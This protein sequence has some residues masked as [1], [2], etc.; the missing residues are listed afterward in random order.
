[1]A[2]HLPVVES[3]HSIQGEGKHVGKSAF[4]IRLAKCTVGCNWCDTKNSWSTNNHPEKS[5]ECLAQETATARDNGAAFVVITGGEPLH[6]N[7]N[8]LCDA[9]R[10]Q[11]KLN[12]KK[13]I[14]IH[15]ETSGVEELTGNPEWI[16]LSPKRHYPPKTDLLLS[17]QELKIV[18][19]EPEDI[20]FAESMAKLAIERTNTNKFSSS[21][22]KKKLG[23]PFLLL[24][25]GWENKLGQELASDYVLHHPQWSLSLQTHK[26]LG[27]R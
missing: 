19:N 17:C 16:T 1:M 25:P 18:I 8:L 11:T 5:V 9:I 24:Q 12:N 21:V 26:W 4:F 7:L 15:I 3:F 14:A 22:N 10:D 20:K 23:Y 13:S 27:I 2:T 6:H